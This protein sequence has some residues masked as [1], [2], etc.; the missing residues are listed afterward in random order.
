M[1][2]PQIAAEVFPKSRPELFFSWRPGYG[3]IRNLHEFCLLVQQT[4][5]RA[6]LLEVYWIIG[7]PLVDPLS[8]LRRFVRVGYVC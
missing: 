1:A 6:E 8:G 2:L 4:K 7:F 5:S 3:V